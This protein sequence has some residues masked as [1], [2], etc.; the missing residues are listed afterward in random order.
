[1]QIHDTLFAKVAAGLSGFS[2]KRVQFADD[3]SEVDSR[4]A[5]CAAVARGVFPHGNAAGSD[6]GETHVP[7]YF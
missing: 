1:V 4:S 2:V 3:I 5:F 6:L 7:R